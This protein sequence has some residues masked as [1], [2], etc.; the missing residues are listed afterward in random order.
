MSLLQRFA[1]GLAAMTATA[2]L[3]AGD[4]DC[5]I[6]SPYSLDLKGEGIAF[7]SKNSSP[8]HVRMDRGHLYIDGRE[9]TLSAQDRRTIHS[10][11][12]EVRGISAEAVVIAS[13]GIDI[14][15]DALSEVS[16][17]LIENSERQTE[18]IRS[19]EKTR[20]IVQTQIRDAVLNRPFDERAFEALVEAQIE[21]MAGELVKVVVGEFVPRA[22]AAAL[23]GDE[24]MVK[25][26]EARAERLEAEIEK[27]IEAKAREIERRAETLCPRVR[28]LVE[29]EST[30]ALRLEDGSRLNLIEN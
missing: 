24:A 13:D 3:L 22:I 14:A 18:M 19:M 17:A 6:E 27:K 4:I 29:L 12:N 1:I 5:D 2:P 8:G 30:L 23:T 7:S 26:I 11:E 28:S 20:A 10:I 9:I 16:R 15:F 25:N 21:T